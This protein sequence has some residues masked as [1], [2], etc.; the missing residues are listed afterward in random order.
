MKVK[1]EFIKGKNDIGY[2]DSNFTSE[3]GDEEFEVGSILKS[4]KLTRSMT[5]SEIIKEFGVQECT[6]G[7]IFITLKNATPE[8]KD[9]YSNLFYVKGHGSR[10]VSV[11]W[12]GD[13][14]YV[15][16]WGRGDGAWGGDRRV[17]SPATAAG[18]LSPQ[19]SDTLEFC[20]CER[21]GQCGKV[22]KKRKVL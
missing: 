4:N 12:G 15:Y 20:S 13:Y 7:D 14:W 19:S 11:R 8:M 16:G 1:D 2:V 9:G 6:L 18:L 3:Y 22:V 10:V 21:C 17:F 5:D